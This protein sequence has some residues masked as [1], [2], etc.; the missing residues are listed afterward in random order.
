MKLMLLERGQAHLPDLRDSRSRFI[1]SDIES[2]SSKQNQINL[3]SLKGRE[4][5]MKAGSPRSGLKL[6]V[7]AN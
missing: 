3:E 7:I 5:T 6:L 2:R 1:T 4:E